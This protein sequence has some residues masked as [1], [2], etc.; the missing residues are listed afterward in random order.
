MCSLTVLR[1]V[2]SIRR[3]CVEGSEKCLLTARRG[4]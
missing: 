1:T 3:P 4:L 2:T